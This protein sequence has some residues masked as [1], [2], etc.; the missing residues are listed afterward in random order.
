MCSGHQPQTQRTFSVEGFSGSSKWKYRG[1][2][3]RP[4]P[5]QTAEGYPGCHLSRLP[6]S[7]P[8]V[9][10]FVY[11]EMTATSSMRRSQLLTKTGL[12]GGE[13]LWVVWPFIR[14]KSI[15][16]VWQDTL[17]RWDHTLR[18]YSPFLFQQL[19]FMKGF[20]C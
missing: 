9:C 17:I 7:W 12:T 2:M 3:T 14:N 18:R 4:F 11:Q 19:T 20:V 1:E 5:Q 16:G 6:L 10:K 13:E 15:R 8:L